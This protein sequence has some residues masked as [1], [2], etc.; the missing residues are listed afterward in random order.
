MLPND[1]KLRWIG[2][3]MSVR[4]CMRSHVRIDLVG[5][6]AVYAWLFFSSHSSTCTSRTELRTHHQHHR[7]SVCRQHQQQQHKYQNIAS[8]L[9]ELHI[10]DEG[11]RDKEE[12]S[13][14]ERENE[15]NCGTTPLNQQGQNKK[16][17]KTTK[18]KITK[19]SKSINRRAIEPAYYTH[20]GAAH[21]HTTHA[22]AAE[23]QT[24]AIVFGDASV[25]DQAYNENVIDGQEWVWVN[26][27]F[28]LEFWWFLFVCLLLLVWFFFA[29]CCCPVLLRFV[30]VEFYF[31]T[32][33]FVGRSCACVRFMSIW[34]SAQI[35]F[36]SIW[37]I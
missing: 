13:K 7:C 5:S 8:T 29:V 37:W 24:A 3:H 18:T 35:F 19:L 4:V 10:Y 1:L 11:A 17:Q 31:I 14:V 23:S 9:S 15:Q 6:L 26:N 30:L 36:N 32:I 20:R 16:K 22:A 27:I 34:N 2:V 33:N 12:K 28:S 21:T 25:I